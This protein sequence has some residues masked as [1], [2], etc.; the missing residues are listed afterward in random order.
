MNALGRV[1]AT[2]VNV[3]CVS[4][5]VS[6]E[7]DKLVV[8]LNFDVTKPSAGRLFYESTVTFHLVHGNFTAPTLRLISVPPPKNLDE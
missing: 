7:D 3:R 5:P 1:D 8:Q 4:K 6:W 2:A